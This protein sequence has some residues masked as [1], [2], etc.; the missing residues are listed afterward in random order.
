MAEKTYIVEH[1]DTELEAWSTLEYLTISLETHKSGSKFFLTSV[2][3]EFTLP[4]QLT[5]VEGLT[6]EHDSVEELYARRKEVV[7]LLDPSAK[8][9]LSPEDG[10][11]FEVFLFG[12]ILGTSC[13]FNERGQN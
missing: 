2:P 10:K 3:K 12:G 4:P 8:Q 9:E 7:C 5:G 1:L 13:T 6:V 11:K